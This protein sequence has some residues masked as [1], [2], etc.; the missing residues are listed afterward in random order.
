MKNNKLKRMVAIFLAL[1]IVMC[2]SACSGKED[3][4]QNAAADSE[5]SKVGDYITFGAYEQD[6]DTSNGKEPIEWLVLDNKDD[7]VLVISKYALDSQPYNEEGEEVTWETCTLRSW[8][9]N[10]FVNVA[11]TAEEKSQIPTTTVIAEDSEEYGT[12][13]GKDTQDK[14]F[15]LSIGE[16]EKYFSSAEARGC[17]PTAYA[18]AQG[19]WITTE[20]D[21]ETY[22]IESK[23]F[24]NCWCWWL[25]SPGFNQYNASAVLY[26]GSVSGYDCDVDIDDWAVR[27]AMWINLK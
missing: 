5:K 9:N 22:G 8:L 13:A 24:G 1:S 16:A 6:N 21:A 11:F 2:L 25:R 18:E 14:V 20:E 7:K 26:E 10:E 27:P 4:A 12:D 15:L 17:K 3:K 19:L 23:Y